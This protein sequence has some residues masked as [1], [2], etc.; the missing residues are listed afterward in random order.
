MVDVAEEAVTGISTQEIIPASVSKTIAPSCKLSMEVK[1][2]LQS[3]VML[4]LSILKPPAR[5]VVEL[6]AMAV[7]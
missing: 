2:E 4:P 3:W 7:K 1:P 5:V 6:V